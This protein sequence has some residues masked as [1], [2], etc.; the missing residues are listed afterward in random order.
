MVSSLKVE[1]KVE[2][3]NLL[4]F[5]LCPFLSLLQA[6]LTVQTRKNEVTPAVF[7]RFNFIRNHNEL[8]SNI[9]KS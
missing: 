6:I 2:Q 9:K 1:Q 8:G 7:T 3:N 5:F 4:N